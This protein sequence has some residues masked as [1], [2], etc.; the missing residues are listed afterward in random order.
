MSAVVVE[1]AAEMVGGAPWRR[2]VVL[3]GSAALVRRPRRGY[4]PRSWADLVASA[5]RS[6]RPD[7]A[8]RNFGRYDTCT[9][10]VRAG[11]LADALAFRG[12]LAAVVAGTED[13]LP[14]SF[15]PDAT[16]AEL[17][18]IAGPL[19]DAGA[20]VVLVGPYDV[21]RSAAVAEEDRAPVR[22]R[23]RLLSERTHY[24]SLRHGAY[25][26]DLI[27]HPPGA[28]NGIHAVTAA[29]VLRTLSSG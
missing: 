12:D 29:A 5:L 22:K 19:R 21:S 13:A 8:Y 1:E 11:Q 9:A 27:S 26:V 24:L 14:G 2:F 7:L 23:L 18:R 28:G 3:G 6:E 10:G 16:E 15:D 17:R 4:A 20:D 25:F